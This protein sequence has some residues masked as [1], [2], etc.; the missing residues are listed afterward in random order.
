MFYILCG[1]TP[2]ILHENM[3]VLWLYCDFFSQALIIEPFI[4]GKTTVFTR[5][6]WSKGSSLTGSML[7]GSP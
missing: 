6:L 2:L 4:I 1:C 5:S 3:I 7:L